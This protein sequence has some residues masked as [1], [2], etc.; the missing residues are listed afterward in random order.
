VTRTDFFQQTRNALRAL[1]V[2]FESRELLDFTEGRW[3]LRE[4]ERTPAAWARAFLAE[5]ERPAFEARAEA[6]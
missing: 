1:A 3:P 6:A 2:P 4:Q 5:Q